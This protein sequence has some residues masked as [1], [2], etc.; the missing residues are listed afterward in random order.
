MLM[1]R[2]RNRGVSD[3]LGLMECGQERCRAP[4]GYWVC[5]SWIRASLVQTPHISCFGRR[6]SA[7]V[8]AWCSNEPTLGTGVLRPEAPP[9]GSPQPNILDEYV[10]ERGLAPA[11]ASGKLTGPEDLLILEDEKARMVLRGADLPI[12]SLVTGARRLPGCSVH[13]ILST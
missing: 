2:V 4:D 7:G 5:E 3:F 6:P 9:C 8:G 1:R 13:S 10:K 12:A 11:A